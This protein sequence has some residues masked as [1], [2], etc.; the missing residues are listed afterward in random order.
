MGNGA[1]SPLSAPPDGV[2]SSVLV[3]AKKQT[4]FIMGVGAVVG[5]CGM[6][7]RRAGGGPP[8]AS[9][10]AITTTA[11]CAAILVWPASIPPCAPPPTL[12]SQAGPST[13]IMVLYLSGCSQACGGGRVNQ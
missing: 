8:A 13:H 12:R 6:E 10:Q 4:C 5:V 2:R 3:W 1:S 11:A 9:Q 7:S